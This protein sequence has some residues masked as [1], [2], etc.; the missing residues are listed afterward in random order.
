MFTSVSCS[1]PEG[2]SKSSVTILFPWV[3]FCT[4]RVFL[5]FSDGFHL[6]DK[7]DD[8]FTLVMYYTVCNSKN[9][10]HSKWWKA[11]LKRV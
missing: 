6:V 1:V 5:Y 2:I 10:F 8:N 7:D 3:F 11:Q 9:P 4:S